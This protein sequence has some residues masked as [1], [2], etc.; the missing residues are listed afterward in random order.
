MVYED[1]E[2]IDNDPKTLFIQRTLRTNSLGFAN[3][4]EALCESNPNL[5]HS[6]EIVHGQAKFY[7]KSYN[8]SI[9]KHH[10]NIVRVGK[11]SQI[12]DCCVRTTTNC[13]CFS[14]Y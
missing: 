11:S 6:P 5:Q 12:V 13:W 3:L 4:F 14:F 8:R 7:D 10:W 9:K 2:K 1:K